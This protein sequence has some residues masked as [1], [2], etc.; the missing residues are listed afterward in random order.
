MSA[1]SQCTILIPTHNRPEYL[2][3]CVRWFSEFSCPIV[4]ADSSA[5]ISCGGLQSARLVHLH[6]PGGFEVYPRKLQLALERVT[7][8]FVAMCADD[9]F[10][11]NEGLKASVLFLEENPDYVFSQGY[12]YLYQR[13]GSRLALWPMVYPFHNNLSDTWLERVENAR[14]TVYYG[15][16][17]TEP[18]SK[19]IDFLV[20]QDFS[21]I[22]D[23]VAGFIDA[24]ITTHIARAGKFKR[25]EV[26]FAFR[27]YSANVNAVG[28]RFG[29]IISRNVPD[30]YGNLLKSLMQGDEDPKMRQRLFRLLAADYA[31][32]LTFDLGAPSGHNAMRERLPRWALPHAEYL[33]RLYGAIKLYSSTEY[34]PF[35]KVFFGKDYRRFKTFVI[36]GRN[37]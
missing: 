25:C 5:L 31:G 1:I 12:A 18:L 21:E 20:R 17:R 36:E 24:A 7:T 37:S 27:E 34:R 3:R 26:P 33:F 19:A 6:C 28:R 30:F 9:D 4:I 10:I 23:G 35:L 16:N 11:A 14:S 29:S 22:M 32:Q 15:V 13:F 8:P 2:A